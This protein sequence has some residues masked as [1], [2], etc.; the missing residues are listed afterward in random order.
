MKQ[1]TSNNKPFPQVEDVLYIK[2]QRKK[3]SSS[4]HFASN[5]NQEQPKGISRT[6]YKCGKLGHIKRD[7]RVKVKCDRCGKLGHIKSNCRVRLREA[8]TNVA[9]E[10]GEF[11]QAD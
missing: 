11:Q 10:S 9:H 2:D 1:V 5:K 6:C 4:K 8:E 3:S 7:C